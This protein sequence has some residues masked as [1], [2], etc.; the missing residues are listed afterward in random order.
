MLLN[1][2]AQPQAHSLLSMECG[3]ESVPKNTQLNPLVANSRKASLC[4]SRLRIG[5]Q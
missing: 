1:T 3:A 2:P 5:K 4:S